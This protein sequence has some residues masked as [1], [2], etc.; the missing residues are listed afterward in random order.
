MGRRP[1]WTHRTVLMLEP[2]NA[3]ETI[4]SLFGLLLTASVA[5]AAL[6]YR[7]DRWPDEWRPTPDVS[8]GIPLIVAAVAGGLAVLCLASAV[9]YGRRWRTAR[10]IERLSNDPRLGPLLP[11]TTRSAS[12]WAVPSAAEIP[13]LTVDTVKARKLPRVKPVV[14]RVTAERNVLGA[15]PLRIAYLRL[16]DN[17]PRIRTFLEGAWREFGYIV[18]LRSATSV[19]P[20]EYRAARRSGDLAGLFINSHERL[21]EEL[22]RAPRQPLGRGRHVIRA[23]APR[24]V[25]TRDSHGSYPVLGLLCHGQFWQAALDVVLSRVDL[26]VLDLSGFTEKNVGTDYEL[27]RVVDR[28]PLERV[29]FL[30]D[31]RSNHRF[32][33][34]QIRA[35]WRAMAD[36]SPNVGRRPRNA[37]VAIT[38][39]L[40]SSQQQSS[41]GQTTTQVRLVA[42]RRRSRRVAAVA[43][44]RARGQAA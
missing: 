22:G 13:A 34:E 32:L 28:V 8:S 42:N 41:G 20:A 19:S 40:V 16:F 6:A 31:E 18:L 2:K 26:V 27:Q 30:A 44:A 21:D 10:A 4:G 23:I 9:V 17:Q 15:P 14:R 24:A 29:V 36:G 3:G 12:A 5:V 11:D 1:G 43:A 25:R 39:H 33:E 38:D 37:L 35:A 7:T